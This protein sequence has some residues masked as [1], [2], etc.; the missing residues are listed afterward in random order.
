M[1][2]MVDLETWGTKAGNAIRSI[3]ACVFDPATG[4]LGDEFYANIT[5][6]SCE[7]YGL[8]KLPSTVQWWAQQAAAAQ[9]AL[10]TEQRDLGEVLLDFRAWFLQRGSCVW[11]Y[12]A[13][14]DPV[15]LEAAF[16]ACLIDVPW[17]FWNVRCCRT[18]L[19]IANRKPER[20]AK[21]TKHNALDDAKAQARAVAAAFRYGQFSAR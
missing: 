16:E 19:A 13:N 14:F 8:T 17:D 11:G 18:V 21:E 15:L 5:D 9:A 20:F 6:A 10:Q 7:A 4:K 2:V 12:G 3:G 1:H